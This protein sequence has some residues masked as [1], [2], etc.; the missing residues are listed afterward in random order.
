MVE[1]NGAPF[2]VAGRIDLLEAVDHHGSI[3]Q[4]AKAVGMSYKGAWDAIDTM[5]NQADEALVARTPGGRRGGGTHLTAYGKRVVALVRAIEQEYQQALSLL[6]ERV[7][8]HGRDFAEYQRLLQRF[9]LQTS[10][11]N[12]WVGTITAIRADRVRTEVEIALDAR[13]SIVAHVTTDSARRLGIQPG[14][15]IA[16]LVKAVAV[17]IDTDTA[18]NT[19]PNRLVGTIAR[20]SQEGGRSEVSIDLPGGRTI[21]AVVSDAAGVSLRAG[22][23]VVASFEPRSVLLARLPGVS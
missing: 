11:R 8:K 1:K 15:D 4:A 6:N 10:A 21:T 17:Q 13:L 14:V 18:R 20:C 12:H 23:K 16:A 22:R 7:E 3:S 9:S 5:N 19:P 2:L